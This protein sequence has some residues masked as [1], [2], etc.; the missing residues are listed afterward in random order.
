MALQVVLQL[1]PGREVKKTGQLVPY[2]PP[3]GSH[4]FF[5]VLRASDTKR[6]LLEGRVQSPD[7]AII[8][9]GPEK[10]LPQSPTPCRLSAIIIFP[11]PKP[12]KRIAWLVLLSQKP[13]AAYDASAQIDKRQRGQ[14]SIAA[15]SDAVKEFSLSKGSNT[16]IAS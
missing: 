6:V 9:Q 16:Y 13:I 2:F 15:P 3:A 12:S 5:D 14:G 11:F 4:R 8:H 10:I 7:D 1:A